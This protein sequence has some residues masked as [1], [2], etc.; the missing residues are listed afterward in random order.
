MA[1][2][3]VV[4][5]EEGDKDSA[6]RLVS[7]LES[8]GVS[9]FKTGAP[10]SDNTEQTV[11]YTD[12]QGVLA[13]GGPASNEVYARLEERFS[14]SPVRGIFGQREAVI[15]GI[16]YIGGVPIVGIAGYQEQDTEEAVSGFL[17][18]S[19]SSLLSPGAGIDTFVSEVESSGGSSD[20][21]FSDGGSS[22]GSNTSTGTEY[23][24]KAGYRDL[25]GAGDFLVQ[26]AASLQN[27][28]QGIASGQ[29]KGY[30]IKNVEVNRQKDIVKVYFKETGSISLLAAGTI[31][32]AALS[33]L[34]ISLAWWQVEKQKTKRVKAENNEV[35]DAEKELQEIINNPNAD[36]ETKEAARQT[37]VELQG[38]E[39]SSGSGSSGSGFLGTGISF[40]Q[41]A[42]GVFLVMLVLIL[43]QVADSVP[44]LNGGN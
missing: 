44:D 8:R 4:Y 27:E 39:G 7:A 2:V 22:D 9:A 41:A 19:G 37:L 28:L 16:N 30:E 6:E 17:N 36:Q 1:S 5:G 13:V 43:L 25:F 14:W 35:D 23:V 12:F 34:G 31:I 32:A 26:S 33:S 29:L 3:V 11:N 20:G 15:N 38:K 21:G 40:Q 42:Q 10:Q 24:F 18:P